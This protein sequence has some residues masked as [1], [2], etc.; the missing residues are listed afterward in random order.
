MHPNT[1]QPGSSA[2]ANL[3]KGEGPEPNTS[4]Q[5]PRYDLIW[6]TTL[7]CP[8]DCGI[9]CVDAVHVVG[10]HGKVKIRSRGLSETEVIDQGGASSKYDSALR[11]RQLQGREL[12]WEKKMAVLDHLA[13]ESVRMDISG[14]DALTVTEG[15]NLLQEVSR[16]FGRH[17]VTL[18]VTGAG[19]RKS[20]I[21][22][23]ASLIGEFNFSFDPGTSS[24][25]HLRPAGYSSSNL[26]L[27]KNMSKLG[28]PVRAEMPLTRFAINK[29]T[30]E[31]IYDQL[32][33][34]GVEHLL[35]MRLFAVGRGLINE[36]AIPSRLE[37]L[38]AIDILQNY[39]QRK[40]GPKVKLQ[41]ALRHIAASQGTSDTAGKNPCDLVTESFGLMADGTLLAS[42]WAIG[43]TGDPLD[44]S[45]VLG[46]LSDKPFAQLRA[47]GVAK[48]LAHRAH[49]NFGHCKVFAFQ[50]S[51]RANPIDRMTD[52]ADP[53]FANGSDASKANKRQV[54]WVK[55][56]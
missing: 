12:T 46:N 11:H 6:N 22:T 45:F 8:W 2:K 24:E 44:P 33:D 48:E 26:Q 25:T 14:G 13:G 37:Y 5:R 53:L 42:P 16:R 50:H 38:Q 52:K 21:S 23:T 9:C 3:I 56:I 1:L 19:L 10:D 20:D 43:P 39:A 30:L 27:A 35:L 34:A 17:N 18:T 49:E 31:K 36:H 4:V 7:V 28:V 32:A 51:T 47:G 15:R 40:K 55:P 54:T 41:C 29:H